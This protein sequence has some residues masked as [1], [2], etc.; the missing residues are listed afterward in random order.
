VIN[1]ID[2][3]NVG[4]LVAGHSTKLIVGGSLFCMNPTS[5]VFS[6]YAIFMY[7]ICSLGALVCSDGF[8]GRVFLYVNYRNMT[9]AILLLSLDGLVVGII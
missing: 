2:Y 8:C 7:P 4:K 3:L 5:I 1:S 9:G 6:G